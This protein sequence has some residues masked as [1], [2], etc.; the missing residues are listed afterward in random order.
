MTKLTKMDL[1][2]KGIAMYYCELCKEWVPN[3]EK[4]MKKRHGK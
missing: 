3:K 2:K 4:H 1:P